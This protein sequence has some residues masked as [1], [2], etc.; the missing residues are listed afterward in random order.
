MR[1]RQAVNAGR[2][3]RLASAMASYFEDLARPLTATAWHVTFT[4]RDF[5]ASLREID[6]DGCA[7]P[8]LSSV[9]RGLG[10]CL[11][12][13][14]AG[15]VC[16]ELGKSGERGRCDFCGGNAHAHAM[17]WLTAEAAAE[18]ERAWVDRCGFLKLQGGTVEEVATAYAAKYATK[19]SAKGAGFVATKR[20]CE[21]TERQRR[22][23]VCGCWADG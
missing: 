10:A 6:G 20:F 15:F 5:P 9:R 4:H 3:E 2:A 7:H 18:L 8:R 19:D 13:D 22:A 17:L 21:H 1:E 12:G 14:S 11:P 16:G 23:G